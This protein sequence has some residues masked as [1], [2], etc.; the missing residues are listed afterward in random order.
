MSTQDPAP[1]KPSDTIRDDLVSALAP[2][3]GEALDPVDLARRDL[4][5]HLPKRFYER[6]EAVEIDGQWELRLDGKAARSPARHV[7]RDASRAVME[8]VAAEWA[9]QGERVDPASMPMTRLLNVA[10]DAVPGHAGEVAADIVKYA[11]SDLICYRASEPQSLVAAEGACWNPII[12]WAQQTF[13]ARFVLAEGVMF[14][15]QPE[16]ATAAIGRAVEAARDPLTL[17]ALHSM[18]TLTGSVLLALAVWKARL[19]ADDAWAAAHVGE[20]YQMKVWGQDAE[21][22][23]RRAARWADMQAAATA[24]RA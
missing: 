16:S 20:D 2:K 6:A 21:A 7:L 15:P 10:L 5:K 9:A 19:A 4:V 18:T 14:A 13:G 8:A 24:A 22:L 23:A 3:G 1:K 17:A 12:E 11:G